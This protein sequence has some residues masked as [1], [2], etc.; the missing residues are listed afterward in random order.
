MRTRIA[1]LALAATALVAAPATAHKTGQAHS[2]GKSKRCKPHNVAYVASGILAGHTLVQTEGAATTDTGDDRYSGTLT[3]NVKRTN[4]HA[5]GDDE[6]TKTYTLEDDKVSF[7][8]GVTLQTAV[9]GQTRVKV[10][11][12]I[13]R[14]HRKCQ[15]PNPPAQPNIRKAVFK[16]PEEPPA[17]S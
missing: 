7:G 12:K 2:H 11:G 13:A 15:Q 10:I 1:V 8:E 4:K 6:T 17:Q 16:A 5:R 14:V 9:V 3:I